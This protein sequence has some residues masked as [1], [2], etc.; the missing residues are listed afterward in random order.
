MEDGAESREDAGLE[1]CSDAATAKEEAAS[2]SEGH[3]SVPADH[4]VCGHLSW[5]PQDPHEATFHPSS[6]PRGWR[7]G[8]CGN[9][10]KLTSCTV[11]STCS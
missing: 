10:D 11:T 3:M 7:W 9:L 2:G 5:Q 4:P 1:G 6:P 8:L